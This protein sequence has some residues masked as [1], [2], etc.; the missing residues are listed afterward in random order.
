ME[1]F[2]QIGLGTIAA[3]LA[4]S[5]ELKDTTQENVKKILRRL[6]LLLIVITLLM[7][8]YDVLSKYEKELD[9][10]KTADDDRKERIGNEKQIL[11]NVSVLYDSLKN[12]SDTLKTQLAVQKATN[13]TATHLMK[14][15]NDINIREEQIVLNLERSLNPITPIKVSVYYQVSLDDENLSK[16]KPYILNYSDSICRRNDSLQVVYKKSA[17]FKRYPWS[18]AYTG[19]NGDFFHLH[20][21]EKKLPFYTRFVLSYLKNIELRVIIPHKGNDS[22]NNTYY[23]TKYVN[24]SEPLEYMDLAVDMLTQQIFITE[25]YT[26]TE[27]NSSGIKRSPRAIGFNDLNGAILQFSNLNL[28]AQLK[29]IELSS[30]SGIKTFLSIP[31]TEKQF[32]Y[33]KYYNTKIYERKISTSNFTLTSESPFYE[34]F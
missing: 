5:S 31:F 2:I 26:I 4:I 18:Q 28:N 14:A 11:Q 13:R 33:D 24:D 9:D 32:K 19:L 29:L 7:N 22:F 15:N 12:M 20:N 10:K 30:T 6:A 17:E 16:F 3:I 8:I 23:L 34:R 27:T 1:I 25:R 21:L